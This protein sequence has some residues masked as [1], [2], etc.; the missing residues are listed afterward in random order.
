MNT[1]KIDLSRQSEIKI[2]SDVDLLSVIED[3][4]TILY[5][6]DNN[7][8]C[9]AKRVNDDIT[10][11]VISDTTL[12]NKTIPPLPTTNPSDNQAFV[13]GLIQNGEALDFQWV[14][15]N[16][17]LNYNDPTG[18]GTTEGL[19]FLVQ[20]TQPTG[21]ILSDESLVSNGV[22]KIFN[23]AKQSVKY[24]IDNG[25]IFTTPTTNNIIYENLSSD[26]Y[27][28]QIM[29]DNENIIFTQEITLNALPV[30]VISFELSNETATSFNAF[31]SKDSDIINGEPTNL[32]LTI[33]DAQANSA[34]QYSIDGVN[35]STITTNK[36]FQFQINSAGNYTAYVRKYQVKYINILGLT[37]N[38]NQ[39]L[40]DNY[41][42]SNDLVTFIPINDSTYTNTVLPTQYVV[43][44]ARLIYLKDNNNVVFSDIVTIAPNLYNLI[45]VT[46]NQIN[47]IS[48]QQELFS[49]IAPTTGD[50]YNYIDTIDFGITLLNYEAA[51][52]VTL[53]ID[54]L[55][56]DG[57]DLI[58][59][60]AY[61]MEGDQL[62]SSYNLSVIISELFI[63]EPTPG[64]YLLN[65]NFDILNDIT[66]TTDN[67]Q[68]NINV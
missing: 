5:Q 45:T 2:I 41:S 7:E 56:G 9:H 26:V 49:E 66:I 37:I 14:L 50:T 3:G 6:N 34:Y 47:V 15:S 59:Q 67:Y 38:G 52:G 4:E 43:Q 60:N 24:S 1:T 32:T 20:T 54:I 16:T 22:I 42:F 13:L 40:L 68:V 10:I 35:Y 58:S 29:N 18:T 30:G 65:F 46:S 55:T 44:N 61:N 28:I 12:L 57:L 64:E 63:E 23:Y 31:L 11:T 27:N 33:N 36:T 39:E 25:L 21:L 19:T 8:L 62:N 48:T 17:L 53:N 51:S